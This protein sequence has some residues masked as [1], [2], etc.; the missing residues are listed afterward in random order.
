MSSQL[1][2]TATNNATADKAAAAAAKKDAKMHRRSRTGCFTC[3]LRRKKCDEGRNACKACKHLGLQCEY[4]RPFWWGNSEQRKRQKEAIKLMIKRTKVTEKGQNLGQLHQHHHPGTPDLSHSLPTSDTY[5]DMDRTRSASVD[6]QYSLKYDFEQEPQFDFNAFPGQTHPSHYAPPFAAFSPYEVEHKT[7]RQTYF[8]DINRRESTVSSVS[9]YSSSYQSASSLPPP[10]STLGSYTGE[11]W[12]QDDLYHSAGEEIP[13]QG[14]FDFSFGQPIVPQIPLSVEEAD[15]RLLHH[16]VDNVLRLMFPILELNQHGLARSEVILPALENNKT[17]LHCCLSYS[18]LHMKTTQ[19]IPGDQID[20]D[21]MRHREATIA[22]LCEALNRDEDNQDHRQILEAT[23]A[24][25]VF[26]GAVGHAGDD[27]RDVPWHAHFQAATSLVNKME[28][29]RQLSVSDNINQ[30][31]PPFN[32]TLT[33]WI[34]ILGATMQARAPQ[35][36]NTYREK[37]LASSPSGLSELMGCDDR[38]MYLIS[39]IAVLESLKSEG[40][41]PLQILE[42]VKSLG[43]Q[44]D[45]TEPGPGA[46]HW[47]YTLTGELIPKQLSQNMTA[48]FRFAARIHLCSLIPGSN[49]NQPHIVDLVSKLTDCLEYIPEGPNGFDR[50]IVWPLLIGGAYSTPNSSFRAFFQKRADRLGEQAEFGNFGR[51]NCLLREV[52]QQQPQ[53]VHWRDVMQQKGWDFLLI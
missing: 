19:R 4:K 37:H 5:S 50:S 51:I 9:S 49:P 6:S 42:Q 36:A 13:E 44:L 2:T 11:N 48:A 7:E 45:L 43:N 1:S 31:P 39:E 10:H 20:N 30:T 23:L 53:N 26:Q 12:I 17:Y 47:P 34:D 22:E 28:L 21:I 35:F 46:I 14:F 29:P 40:L 15:Q 16:F 41:D 52:W 24:M 3:R 32:M 33:A 8:N 27:L 25:I 18:A 38:V